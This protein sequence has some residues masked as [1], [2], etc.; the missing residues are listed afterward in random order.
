MGILTGIVRG[1]AGRLPPGAWRATMAGLVAG[2]AALLV[3]GCLV[4]TE[5]LLRPDDS[6][7]IVRLSGMPA[8]DA[9]PGAAFDG[10]TARDYG[11]ALRRIVV[12]YATWISFSSGRPVALLSESQWVRFSEVMAREVP[13]LA[14]DQRLEFQFKDARFK[15]DVVMAVHGEGDFLVFRFTSLVKDE[16]IPITRSLGPQD[17]A[18]LVAQAGQELSESE[19]RSILREPMQRDV[20]SAARELQGKRD[21]ISTALREE[22]VGDLEAKKLLDI[23]RAAPRLPVEAL[24]TYMEKR[25]TLATARRQALLTREEFRTRLEKLLKELRQ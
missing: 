14:P 6:T 17:Q 13:R 7:T 15:L 5:V 1:G 11:A 4:R 8:A 3:A 9:P 23:M 20:A 12:R 18:D 10:L 22:L 24:R 25:K 19:E 21:L 2:L 16:D